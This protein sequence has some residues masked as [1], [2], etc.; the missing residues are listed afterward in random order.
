MLHTAPT[1]AFLSKEILSI[2]YFR[3]QM[4][5]V[6]MHGNIYSIFFDEER[7]SFRIYKLNLQHL[8]YDELPVPTHDQK[9]QDL[10]LYIQSACVVGNDI[11]IYAEKAFS[12]AFI[13]KISFSSSDDSM[14]SDTPFCELI[15][16]TTSEYHRL[17][18][19]P[20]IGDSQRKCLYL[21]GGCYFKGG[22]NRDV[23]KFDIE[24]RTWS[25]I[26]QFYY[27]PALY[28]QSAT[29]W[30]NRYIVMFGGFITSCAACSDVIAF[31]LDTKEWWTCYKTT[32]YGDADLLSPYA[33]YNSGI[34]LVSNQYAS[35][36]ISN[37][38]SQSLF[39]LNTLFIYGGFIDT[40]LK[41][42]N[43]TRI[44]Q[45]VSHEV[46]LFPL[47]ESKWVSDDEIQ[48]IQPL[49][50]T[51]Y[52]NPCPEK[53]KIHEIPQNNPIFSTHGFE[54]DN[55]DDSSEFKILPATIPQGLFHYY[56]PCKGEECLFVITMSNGQ[57]NEKFK[58]RN[59]LIK[60]VLT[61]EQGTLFKGIGAHNNLT[62]TV[63][64]HE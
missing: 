17:Y 7:N 51:D 53:L 18:L 21:I 31:D 23:L 25:I 37:T 59:C 48:T 63:F 64:M 44:I 2:P 47:D 54:E 50:L 4:V 26:S 9:E 61:K 52:C 14:P 39:E 56:N 45:R 22:Y 29:L 49:S 38:T 20:L 8:E 1:K 6:S 33:R 57:V 12:S 60:L 46:L 35:N 10:K 43:V 15:H 3:D 16:Q 40:I 13:F 32:H 28:L 58:D 11:Y 34:A 62:D 24:Q 41:Y 27:S 55:Q 30:K 36:F 5:H 42:N 19:T